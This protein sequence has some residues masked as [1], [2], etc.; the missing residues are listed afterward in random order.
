MRTYQLT[1]LA[2]ALFLVAAALSV[3]VLQV[4][5]T[6]L[7]TPASYSV[8]LLLSIWS[9]C[10]FSAVKLLRVPVLPLPICTGAVNTLFHERFR[11]DEVGWAT[12]FKRVA[13]VLVIF[14][15]ALVGAAGVRPGGG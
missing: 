2:A 4:D 8:S 11:H 9:G 15:G 5:P 12:T 6:N 10:S 7:E 3:A 13:L 1:Q 14:A